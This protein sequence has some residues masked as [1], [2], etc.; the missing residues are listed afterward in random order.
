[1]Q[2]ASALST[3]P[4]VD[5]AVAEV[6]A[7]LH[8]RR[9]AP[10]DLCVVFASAGYRGELDRLPALLWES[11]QPRQLIGCTGGGI[12]GAGREIEGA[13]ALSVTL[14][15]L[16]G[17]GVEVRHLHDGDLPDADAGPDAWV[18]RLGVAPAAVRGMVVLPEPFSFDAPRL[19]AGLDF[20]YPRAAKVGG[21]A[22]GSQ[23]PDG[24][25][26]FTGR[27][28]HRAGAVVASM[29]GAV[30]FAPLLAQGC[31]PFGRIGTITAAQHNRLQQ[32]DQLPALAFLEEQLAGLDDADRE[33]ATTRPVFLGIAM[34][35]FV[36]TDELGAGAWLIR[37]LIGVD[38]ASGALDIGE[39]L[40]HGRRVQFH[41]MDEHTSA[42]DLR[43]VLQ[44]HR[45]RRP[46]AP[47]GA[48]LFSCLGRG[49][50]LYGEADH[51]SRL[52]REEL[53]DVPLGGFFC[54]GEIGPVGGTTYLHGYTSAFAVLRPMIST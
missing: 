29:S 44:R 25:A 37:N 17:V 40:A 7:A 51:D 21:I 50:H 41:L 30:E 48:L 33:L 32:V 16:P 31:K 4:R 14:A 53:S 12:I 35:P 45:A 52:F 42:A 49:R 24:H 43:G 46:A 15:S 9:V 8:P 54:N 20:A 28:A 2:F 6:V 1:M 39:L 18:E 5:D 27:Q 3:A 34:D 26:L 36:P 22:S 23:T 47:A 38:E 11:L 13:P 19:L 10:I